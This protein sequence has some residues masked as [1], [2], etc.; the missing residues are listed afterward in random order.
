V[1]VGGL[2]GHDTKMNSGGSGGCSGGR[3][4]AAVIMVVLVKLSNSLH[5]LCA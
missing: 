4:V 5:P 3:M 2:S 1:S